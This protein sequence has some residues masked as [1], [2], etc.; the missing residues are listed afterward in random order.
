MSTL[1]RG[2]G[3]GLRIDAP[4]VEPF[5]QGRYL[6][7][8]ACSEA[9]LDEALRPRFRVFNEEL[10]EGWPRRS[11]PVATRTGSTPTVIIFWW[12]TTSPGR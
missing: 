7:R 12:R 2:A 3:A 1:E 5:R 6:V 10:G 11:R 9:D 4:A 8:W